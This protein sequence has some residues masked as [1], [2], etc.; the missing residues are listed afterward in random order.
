MTAGLIIIAL[1]ALIAV[2]AHRRTR[3]EQRVLKNVPLN[4]WLVGVVLPAFI[5]VSWAIIVKNIMNRP[6]IYILAVDD[7]D[8]LFVMFIFMIY[9][10]VGNGIHF[11]SKIIWRY[12]AI[13]DRNK[14]VY[15]VNEMFH[16]KLSHYLVYVSSMLAFFVL[17]LM[18]INHP[19]ILYG[20]FYSML[21]ILLAG[22]IFG[23]SGAKSIFFTNQWFGGYNRPI[24]FFGCITLISL[25]IL[26]RT[27]RLSLINYPISF[28][29]IITNISFLTSFFVRQ[30][31]IFTKL[32]N[33]HKLR[34]LARIFS[35]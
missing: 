8:I 35:A 32:N 5:F 24:S 19:V 1:V 16:N 6:N 22:A 2:L 31:M 25:I 27:L 34:F 10:F 14:M 13:T 26:Y 21:T 3:F 9:A 12:L 20:N 33:R 11:A 30:L 29:I 17:A 15:K 23:L 18:E 28:F 7:I 4:D